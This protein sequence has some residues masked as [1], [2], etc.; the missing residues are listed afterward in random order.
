MFDKEVSMRRLW[1]T[2]PVALAV[3]GFAGT[4]NAQGV[5]VEL[6]VGPPAAYYYGPPAYAYDYEPGAYSYYA[7]GITV[8]R[9]SRSGDPSPNNTGAFYRKLDREGRGGN[10]SN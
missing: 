4:A 5:G 9:R 3:F 10:T 2:V 8:Y 6:Y 7:P 1:M